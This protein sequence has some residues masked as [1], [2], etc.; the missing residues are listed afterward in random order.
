M[1]VNLLGDLHGKA[2][3][4]LRLLLKSELPVVQLGDFGFASD[5]KHFDKCNL[6]DLMIIGGNHDEYP[7]LVNHPCYLGDFGLIPNTEKTFFCRGAYSV[8][9]S[10]RTP[11]KDWWAEEELTLKQVDKMLDLYEKIKP[12]T[13]LTH[14]CPDSIIDPVFGIPLMTS[15]T[16][17]FLDECFKIHK[18]KLW[19]FGHMHEHK[20]KTVDGCRF[21]CLA[22]G[23]HMELDLL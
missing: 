2:R 21:I 3:Y 7:A 23:E 6:T 5:Y 18:P 19:V 9:K 8:D 13:M 15:W 10:F 20:D 4:L 12:E 16:G 17:R 11:N 1:L 22:E 14:T